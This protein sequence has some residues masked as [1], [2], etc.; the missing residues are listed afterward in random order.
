MARIELRDIVSDDDR[1]AA[2]LVRRGP[3]Q[4]QFVA[5]V[6]ESFADALKDHHACPRCWSINDGAEIVGFVMISDGIPEERLAGDANLVGPYYLWRLLIDERRQ[7]RGYS[8]AALDAVVSYVRS[9]PDGDVLYVSSGQ[10]EGSPRPFYERYGFV[11]TGRLVDEE[12]VL[13]LDLTAPGTGI[14]TLGQ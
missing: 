10:G 2:L 13:E 4:E 14:G 12:I 11:A 6:E 1:A 3:G 9:R 5:S 8:T 7:R